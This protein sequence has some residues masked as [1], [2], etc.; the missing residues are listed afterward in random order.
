MKKALAKGQTKAKAA[1]TPAGKRKI[2]ASIKQ[3]IKAA[4]Q[5]QAKLTAPGAI[6]RC[7]HIA[8][9]DLRAAVLLYKIAGLWSAIT[10]K[11]RLPG[12]SKE[13]LAMTQADWAAVAG[14]S[15][16]ECKNYAIKRLKSHAY[17]IVQ[18]EVHGRGA[19]KKTWVHF[20]ELAYRAALT[21]AGCELK[22]AASF[23]VPGYL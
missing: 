1:I 5:T 9:G 16:S 3:K 21:E 23:G 8:G 14:L 15:E 19:K 13:Y 17:E 2:A 22:V 6:A 20:D 4:E 7:R 12:G 11:M 10:P 18:F